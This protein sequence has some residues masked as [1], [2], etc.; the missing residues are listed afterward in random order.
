MIFG[1]PKKY[2]LFVLYHHIILAVTNRNFHFDSER[3]I[4]LSLSRLEFMHALTKK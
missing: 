2:K 3:R 1:A 4:F